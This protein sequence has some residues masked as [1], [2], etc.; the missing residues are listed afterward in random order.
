MC[1]LFGLISTI[2]NYVGASHGCCV[3]YFVVRLIDV[4]NVKSLMY[5]EKGHRIDIGLRLSE[6]E[7]ED[8]G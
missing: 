2:E 6:L 5:C 8:S 1:R 7:P 4:N 3:V